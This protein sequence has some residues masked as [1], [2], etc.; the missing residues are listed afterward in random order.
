LK[1]LKTVLRQ[2]GKTMWKCIPHLMHQHK[3]PRKGHNWPV[4]NIYTTHDKLSHAKVT[5]EKGNP[6]NMITDRFRVT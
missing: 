4:Y 3:A 5:K 6:A 2:I 1:G